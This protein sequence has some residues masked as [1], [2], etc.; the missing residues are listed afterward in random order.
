M[1]VV[2]TYDEV[3]SSDFSQL[4]DALE[5]VSDG[6]VSP[7]ESD[8][9]EAYDGKRSM[10]MGHESALE[11]VIQDFAGDDGNLADDAAAAFFG[12]SEGQM[13]AGSVGDIHRESVAPGDDDGVWG[14]LE[15]EIVATYGSDSQYIHARILVGDDTGV[16]SITVF[17]DAFEEMAIDE[18]VL[19]VGNTIRVESVVTEE[20][21]GNVELKATTAASISPID[22]EFD[23]PDQN[24]PFDG[25]I[26]D[27]AGTDQDNGLVLRCDVD[28]CSRVLDS[29]SCTE[30]GS[31]TSENYDLRLKL[32]ITDGRDSRTYILDADAVEQLVGLSL[33]DALKRARDA[34]DMTIIS[35]EMRPNLIGRTVTGTASEVGTNCLVDE[36]AVN[37]IPPAVGD[38]LV[39]G[40]EQV[41]A[42][43]AAAGKDS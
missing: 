21:E 31:R 10:L 38:D 9:A 30:H 3:S 16:A 42:V 22:A 13:D 15:G 17:A 14:D 36:I 4:I 26:V 37:D 11:A 1:N 5:T 33:Q 18:S 28:D 20:Y 19:S 29:G 27:F 34:H 24:T 7:S 43:Q 39:D 35:K 6:A 23:V 25:R 12:T 2:Q 32:V 41:A 40:R 8:V